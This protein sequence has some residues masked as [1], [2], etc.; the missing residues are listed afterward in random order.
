MIVREPEPSIATLK[1][2]NKQKKRT[3]SE[4]KRIK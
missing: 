4:K 1:H 2:N 3:E